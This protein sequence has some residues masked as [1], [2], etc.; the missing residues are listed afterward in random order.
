MFLGQLAK[1]TQKQTFAEGTQQFLRTL[2]F[3]TVCWLGSLPSPTQ[4]NR[5]KQI[6]AGVRL[7][8]FFRISRHRSFQTLTFFAPTRHLRFSA[9]WNLRWH[10]NAPK[11]SNRTCRLF[12][13]VFWARQPHRACPAAGLGIAGFVGNFA[14]SLFPVKICKKKIGCE[15]NRKLSLLLDLVFPGSCF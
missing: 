6:A 15:N 12:Q 4:Q 13:N 5:A 8:F 10:S 7:S 11:T 1:Q 9:R 3:A 2:L 14:K